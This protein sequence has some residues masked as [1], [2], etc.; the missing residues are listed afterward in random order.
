MNLNEI[1]KWCL[2]D[3]Q[4]SA[5]EILGYPYLKLQIL[6]NKLYVINAEYISNSL[7]E[8]RQ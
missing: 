2:Q 8:Q 1:A 6:N 3:N 7:M 5:N 4:Y